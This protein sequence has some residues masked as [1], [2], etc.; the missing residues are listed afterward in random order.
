MTITDEEPIRLDGSGRSKRIALPVTRKT[1][2][3][4][5]TP[6]RTS[7]LFALAERRSADNF[8]PIPMSDLATWL[9]YC[10]SVQ[11]INSDDPNR[12]RRFVGSMGAL[13]PAHIIL[14]SPN[15]QWSAYL[16]EEHALGDLIV[17]AQAAS[18]LR[19]RAMQLF[20]SREATLVALIS[21]K[22]LIGSYYANASTLILRDASVL[23]GHA[24]LVAAALGLAFRILGSTGTSSLESIVPNLL[25]RPMASGLAWIGRTEEL[26]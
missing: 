10:A 20:A 19:T 18:H 6:I 24:A 11:S 1:S 9:Y 23:L 8:M 25:F 2:L 12:Q 7:F 5:P 16:S 13:H 17:D 15:G 4:P 21:D 3:P 26:T 22:D 14:G